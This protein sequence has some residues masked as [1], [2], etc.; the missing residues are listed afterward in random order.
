MSQFCACHCQTLHCC[1]HWM[2]LNSHASWRTQFAQGGRGA[3]LAWLQLPPGPAHHCMPWQWNCGRDDKAVSVLPRGGGEQR[4]ETVPPVLPCSIGVHF[5]IMCTHLWDAGN[6]AGWLVL[7]R[8]HPV[9]V[10]WKVLVTLA[11][12]GWFGFGYKEC[13][14]MQCMAHKPWF[15]FWNEPFCFRCPQRSTMPTSLFGFF[16]DKAPIYC[17][18][19]PCWTLLRSV[20]GWISAKF[21]QFA[22]FGWFVAVFT[23][24]GLYTSFLPQAFVVHVLYSIPYLLVWRV[25]SDKETRSLWWGC[26]VWVAH[27]VKVMKSRS[28][29]DVSQL[30]ACCSQHHCTYAVWHLPVPEPVVLFKKQNKNKNKCFVWFL[31]LL[32]HLPP[33]FLGPLELA[34]PPPTYRLLSVVFDNCSLVVDNTKVT[35][36]WVPAGCRAVQYK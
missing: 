5:V 4:L 33:S 8:P 15:T 32:P 9:F 29:D 31:S 16:F 34:S 10:I 3:A 1:Q 22:S 35:A 2:P 19:L 17:S 12:S 20:H 21:G 28:W 14:R 11:C 13:D 24:E 23:C 30:G 25:G 26:Y 27:V 36:A 18:E 7:S 6:S